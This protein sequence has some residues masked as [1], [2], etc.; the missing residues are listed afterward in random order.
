MNDRWILLLIIGINIHSIMN[1]KKENKK[2][3]LQLSK[4]ISITFIKEERYNLFTILWS[5]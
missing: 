4:V 5:D 1:L 3:A 2:I